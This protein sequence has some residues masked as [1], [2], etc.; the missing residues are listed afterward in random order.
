MSKLHVT[1]IAALLAVA[2]VLGAIVVSQTAKLG[3]ASRTSTATA[4]VARTRQL[5]RFEA[6]L[7]RALERKPPALPAAP[8][9]AAVSPSHAAAPQPRV[10][11]RRPPAIVVVSQTHHGD[12]DGGREAPSGG[13]DD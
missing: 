9:A 8:M 12:D 7:R 6:K 4:L 13:G 11:Y 1:L 2:A 3:T 5:D 10:V